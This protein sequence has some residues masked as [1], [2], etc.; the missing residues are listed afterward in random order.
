[1]KSKLVMMIG[2]AVVSAAAPQKNPPAQNQQ[3]A[4]RQKGAS[5]AEDR[6]QENLRHDRQMTEIFKQQVDVQTAHQNA[7][8]VCS[9]D[10]K[11]REDADKKYRQ[12]MV[13]IQIARNNENATHEKNIADIDQLWRAERH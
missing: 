9:N 6:R 10:T 4:A 12:S 5:L 8:A 13:Q 11:C 1:M 7:L 2:L 3:P